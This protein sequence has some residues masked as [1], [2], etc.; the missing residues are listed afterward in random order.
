MH[1]MPHPYF[2]LAGIPRPPGASKLFCIRVEGSQTVARGSQL[3]K[4]P[5][6]RRMPRRARSC[7]RC[8]FRPPDGKAARALIQINA[9]PLFQSYLNLVIQVE[10]CRRSLRKWADAL[11]MH[12]GRVS[13]LDNVD[14]RPMCLPA[15]PQAGRA[16]N[17]AAHSHFS[18]LFK[19]RFG[20]PYWH[21]RD[22]AYWPFDL[23]RGAIGNGVKCALY[24]SFGIGYS[25]H[26]TS[27]RITRAREPG[28]DRRDVIHRE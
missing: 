24:F 17:E 14:D 20:V 7:G 10:N 5:A 15:I 25:K 19:E 11:S 4:S 27:P 28:E 6:S 8:H 16:M 22:L 12:V 18:R 21:A 1:V 2:T 3:D 23:R 9:A 26:Y 13:P